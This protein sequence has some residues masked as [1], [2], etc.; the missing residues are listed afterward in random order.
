MAKIVERQ[1]VAGVFVELGDD[2]LAGLLGLFLLLD[3]EFQE[4]ARVEFWHKQ[5]IHRAELLTVVLL[6]HL[7][8][9]VA[10]VKDLP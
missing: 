8:Q 2:L 5:L 10:A 1:G 3:E 4:L 9:L 7:N 6:K